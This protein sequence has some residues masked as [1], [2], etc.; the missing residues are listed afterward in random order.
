MHQL[1][2]KTMHHLKASKNETQ[3]VLHTHLHS[4][5]AFATLN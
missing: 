1:H 5:S 3:L 4:S 2:T